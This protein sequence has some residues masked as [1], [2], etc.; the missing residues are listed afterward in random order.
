MFSVVSVCHSV[1][2]EARTVEKQAVGIQSK[3]LLV[4]GKFCTLFD[5]LLMGVL[6]SSNAKSNQGA[7]EF[8]HKSAK[9]AHPIVQNVGKKFLEFPAVKH[10]SMKKTFL[11]SYL[12]VE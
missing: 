6:V 9:R 7:Q 4:F 12:C 5:I 3:C 10:F 8:A 1:P 11:F 2:Y